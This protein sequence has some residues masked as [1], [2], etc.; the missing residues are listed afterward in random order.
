MI[1]MEGPD[2]VLEPRHTTS[3]VRSYAGD[4]ARFVSHSEGDRVYPP[5]DFVDL[6]KLKPFL[7]REGAITGD[8][9]HLG[10]N[11][12]GARLFLF[13]PE[14]EGYRM[15]TKERIIDL[16][17][18]EGFQI[19]S[20]SHPWHL[21]RDQ[22]SLVTDAFVATPAPRWN[23]HGLVYNPTRPEQFS[24]ESVLRVVARIQTAPKSFQ[25]YAGGRYV[26]QEGIT[27]LNDVLTD[28]R[29][30]MIGLS[31]ERTNFSAD[32]GWGIYLGDRE[33]ITLRTAPLDHHL[34]AQENMVAAL[35]TILAHPSV[36]DATVLR[37]ELAHME[38]IS[39][40]SDDAV[41]CLVR[42]A[43]REARQRI[44]DDIMANHYRPAIDTAVRD[45]EKDKVVVR[46]FQLM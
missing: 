46:A 12:N 21:Q 22:C 7:V 9:L 23:G 25:G 11:T 3:H 35:K 10:Q 16:I 13:H 4:L 19:H 34:W 30:R 38:P 43:R 6:N 41:R 37:Q 1:L 28:L 44:I 24:S 18:Y 29:D 8:E 27:L 42:G 15:I 5:F 40:K 2:L 26:H 45:L 14:P 31:P 36:S 39:A 32:L 33:G 17:P 20:P